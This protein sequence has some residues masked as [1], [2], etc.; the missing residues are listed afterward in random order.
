MGK[1][2]AEEASGPVESLAL[3]GG[4][5]VQFLMVHVKILGSD[6]L[7]LWVGMEN[8]FKGAVSMGSTLLAWPCW[9][10]MTLLGMERS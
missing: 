1:K 9:A 8:L 3:P 4:G 7:Q 5:Q 6:L 10:S 2:L